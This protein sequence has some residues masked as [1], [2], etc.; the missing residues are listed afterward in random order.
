MSNGR[1]RDGVPD[2]RM[3]RVARA[4]TPPAALQMPV[5]GRRV[6]WNM[7]DS[8]QMTTPHGHAP[9]VLGN[10]TVGAR[11]CQIT[12]TAPCPVLLTVGAQTAKNNGPMRRDEKCPGLSEAC[13]ISLSPGVLPRPQLEHCIANAKAGLARH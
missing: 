3:A 9:S 1:L 2:S 13:F 12:C 8:S 11:E 4:T 7:C 6:V 5:S 10:G